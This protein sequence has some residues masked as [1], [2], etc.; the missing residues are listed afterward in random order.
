MTKNDEREVQRKLRVLQHAERTGQVAK[1]CRYFGIGRASFYRWKRAYQRYGEDGLAGAKTIPKKPPNQ[2]P[3]EVAEKVLHLRRKY[4]LGPERI[5]WN[6]ARYH[7]IKLSDATIHRIL[8]RNG[9]KR[10]PRGTPLSFAEDPPDGPDVQLP[11]TDYGLQSIFP[12]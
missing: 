10:L 8:K 2:M 1:T 9:L 4:H 3:P 11:G 6:L 5:M 12:E 7:G